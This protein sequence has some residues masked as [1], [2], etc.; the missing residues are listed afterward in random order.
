MYLYFS[1]LEQHGFIVSQSI[2]GQDFEQAQRSSLVPYDVAQ[3]HSLVTQLLL[4]R[5]QDVFT[6]MPGT[7]VGMVRS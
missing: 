5:L 1:D 6:P 7:L 4:C 2:V 3:G